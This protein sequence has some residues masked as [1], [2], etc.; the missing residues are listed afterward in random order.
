MARL[1]VIQGGREKSFDLIDDVVF[2]GSDEG[3]AIRVSGAGVA[4][5]HCQILP[6]DGSWRLVHL[7]Q[8]TTTVNGQPAAQHELANGDVLNVGEATITFK[9]GIRPA[10]VAP[11][12]AEPAA[13]VAPPARPSAGSRRRPRRGAARRPGREVKVDARTER[14]AGQ[15]EVLSRRGS[16]KAGL[17]GPQTAGVA[18]GISL[19]AIIAVYFLL[20]GMPSGGLGETF[21]RA[22][23]L[24]ANSKL[25]EAIAALE[26][27]P[28]EA[29]NYPAAQRMIA[30]I[31]AQKTQTVAKESHLWGFTEY[32]N[33]IKYFVEAKVLN[34]KYADSKTAYI[35]VLVARCK[36]FLETAPGHKNEPEVKS[37][38]AKYEPEIAGKAI[39]WIDVFVMADTE[40][41]RA[42][43][44]PAHKLVADWLASNKATGDEYEVGQA[45]RLLAKI[46]RGANQWW[47]DQKLRARQNVVEGKVNDAYS[48]YMTAMRRF[49][50]WPQMLAEAQRHI[51]DLKAG[52]GSLLTE[53]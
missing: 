19:V 28:E 37:L 49:E 31:K 52:V 30:S 27:I 50:G 46:E 47:D 35:R 10:T 29:A 25:D 48:K 21:D 16:R 8:G 26:T 7:G 3:C 22:K 15:R 39:T 42:F 43:Y 41:G 18:V 1:I 13:P 34:P 40:R 2:V 44:G 9:G 12:A 51:D 32:E 17:T 23:T 45:E 53:N 36:N 20:K 38:L 33:N 24:M 11:P 14:A 5:R 6:V 4:P